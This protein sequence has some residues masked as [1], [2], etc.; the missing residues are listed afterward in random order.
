MNQH[1]HP[2]G[3]DDE[4]VG[5]YVIDFF[6]HFFRIRFFRG[7]RKNMPGIFRNFKNHARP[8]RCD[9]IQYQSLIQKR[10]IHWNGRSIFVSLTDDALLAHDSVEWCDVFPGWLFAYV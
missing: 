8:A 10:L 4:V 5:V 7:P 9:V 3:V 1:T 2:G 6:D